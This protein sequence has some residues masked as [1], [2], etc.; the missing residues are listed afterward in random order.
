MS[1]LRKIQDVFSGVDLPKSLENTL[2]EM[3]YSPSRQLKKNVSAVVDRLT[4]FTGIQL[5]LDLKS[6][7]YTLAK[8]IFFIALKNSLI[9]ELTKHHQLKDGLFVIRL[10]KFLK[11]RRRIHRLKRRASGLPPDL[12][13]KKNKFQFF[14]TPFIK[15]KSITS[16]S[17]EEKHS[18]LN[19]LTFK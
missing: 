12:K 15:E 1:K 16:L 7:Y 19:P 10:K 8:S 3:M 2:K 11:M 9:H 17:Y 18:A 13:K 14:S 4:P 5:Q 6:N